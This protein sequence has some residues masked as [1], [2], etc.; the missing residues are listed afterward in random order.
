MLVLFLIPVVCLFIYYFPNISYSVAGFCG[1][2]DVGDCTEQEEGKKKCSDDC[3]EVLKCKY[4]CTK[5]LETPSP[6]NPYGVLKSVFKYQRDEG[7][8]CR[9]C[10]GETCT[11]PA[12]ENCTN[13]DGKSYNLCDRGC[14]SQDT[15]ATCR[16]V[17]C[18]A[19]W[20]ENTKCGDGEE[21][22]ESK[23]NASTNWARCELAGGGK[24]GD[25]AEEAT[26]GDTQDATQDDTQEN[27]QT[28]TQD[29]AQVD[30]QDDAQTDTQD[31]NKIEVQ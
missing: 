28:D 20:G 25:G 24:D 29:G 31:S 15:Y 30:N 14:T 3:S 23:L 8:G 21:C 16:N 19:S 4:L 22:K 27:T 17:N 11:I 2:G 12:G 1:P 6:R 13:A 10:V 5:V 7:C 26:E 9:K 18:S